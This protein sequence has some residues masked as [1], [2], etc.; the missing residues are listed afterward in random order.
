[1]CSLGHKK[2]VM[3]SPAAN[4]GTYVLAPNFSSNGNKF[5]IEVG[6][7]EEELVKHDTWLKEK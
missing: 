7:E 4:I 2:E 5:N 6:L 1:M 3:D